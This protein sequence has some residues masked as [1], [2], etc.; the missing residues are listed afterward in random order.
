MTTPWIDLTYLHL[1]D[2]D[3]LMINSYLSIL[4]LSRLPQYGALTRTKSA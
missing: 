3:E 2:M 4:K 1:S